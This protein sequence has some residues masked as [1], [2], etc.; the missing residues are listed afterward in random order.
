MAL[1][2]LEENSLSW[3]DL[4]HRIKPLEK[5]E[6]NNKHILVEGQSKEVIKGYVAPIWK[7]DE[8]NL[9]GRIYP[10]KLGEKIVKENPVTLMLADHPEDEGSVKDIVGVAKNPFLKNNIMYAECYIVDKAFED[11]VAKIT[12]LGGKIGLS[13]SGLGSLN[14]DNSV[15]IDSFVCERIA[16]W[17]LDPSFSVYV[18][19]SHE[20]IDNKEVKE[21]KESKQTDKPKDK[22][23]EEATK[24]TPSSLESLLKNLKNY[25]LEEKNF[26]ISMDRFIT[27]AKEIKIIETKISKFE[28]LLTWCDESQDFNKP[29]VK[30]IKEELNQ[31][32]SQ[33]NDLAMKGK[34]TDGLIE[35]KT[36]LES[37]LKE[38]CDNVDTLSEVKEDLYEKF[39]EI[40]VYTNELK[41]T[42]NILKEEYSTIKEDLET[43]YTDNTKVDQIIE[44]TEKLELKLNEM[45]E[46]EKTLTE[47][48]ETLHKKLITIDEQKV[49]ED[50]DL[51]DLIEKNKLRIAQEK[52]EELEKEAIEEQKRVESQPNFNRFKQDV[53][54]LYEDWIKQDSR[55]EKFKEEI[56]SC[57]NIREAQ[58]KRLQL[59]KV[60]DEDLYTD[61]FVY[62]S[63]TKKHAKETWGLGESTKEKALD[64]PKGWN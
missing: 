12:E 58:T 28:E 62:S 29:V 23:E 34:Q 20:I 31:L 7:L 13:S 50:A 60:L 16:D 24:E 56:L 44:Y 43:K 3:K 27:E 9:N 49:K 30:V 8:E 26:I 21:M 59:K 14:E 17:V 64:I 33:F 22:I 51:K 48:N 32:G 41:E 63:A 6:E 55:I 4:D 18:E 10:K 38:K 1:I 47:E 40:K 15:D 2:K 53:V 25:N 11:K 36:K 39:D 61:N 42:Y 35:A 19:K 5:I 52:K 57:R 46:L 37:E 45:L 54:D